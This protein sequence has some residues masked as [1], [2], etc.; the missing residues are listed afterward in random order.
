MLK[1][2]FSIWRQHDLLSQSVDQ[3]NEMLESLH[4]MFGWSMDYVWNY[5]EGK[6]SEDIYKKDIS[7]NKTERR[8]RKRLVEHLS[9]QPGDSTNQCLVFMS[10]TKDAERIG[11]YCKNLLE[12][13]VHYGK[14]FPED[15][16]VEA[17][18]NIQSQ[19]E[20]M[21]AKTADCFRND[22]V[23]IAKSVH[24]MKTSLGKDCEDF[25]LRIYSSGDLDVPTAVSYVLISRFFKRVISHLGNISTSVSMPVHKL[26]YY[27]EKVL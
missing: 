9:I 3:F 14:P 11:D 1:Q 6:S 21:F 7:I 15:S 18:K 2:L 16:Y 22:S 13:A 24:H 25:I 27:D 20:E 5:E 19:V 23:E 10:I 26:D 8:I 4:S 12:V 17:L